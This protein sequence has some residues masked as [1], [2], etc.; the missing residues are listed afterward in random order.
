MNAILLH[1]PS[2]LLL[3]TINAPLAAAE[4]KK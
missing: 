2:A 4:M 1:R 3:L